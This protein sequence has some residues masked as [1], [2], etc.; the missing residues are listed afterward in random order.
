LML[1]LQKAVRFWAFQEFS[2]SA[3]HLA[4][5]FTRYAHFYPQ[6]LWTKPAADRGG[7]AA[8]PC[9]ARIST[10]PAAARSMRIMTPSHP[11]VRMSYDLSLFMNNRR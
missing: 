2:R 6:D 9:L 7:A 11:P 10:H 4:P 3:H 1:Q 5:E 8:K